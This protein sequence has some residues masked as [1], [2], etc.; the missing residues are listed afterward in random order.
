MV[1]I[2]VDDPADTVPWADRKGITFDLLADPEQRVIGKFGLINEDRP[3]L[4]LHAI[5]IIDSHGKVFYRKV[6]RRRAYANELLDAIDYHQGR[7]RRP[8]A[9]SGP[10]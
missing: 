4:S 3:E 5:Y 9:K 7:Y 8:V 6:A 10:K 1:G 2:S